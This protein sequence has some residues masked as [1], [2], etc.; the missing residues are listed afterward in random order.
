MG[1]H[2]GQGRF[3]RIQP[4]QQFRIRVVSILIFHRQ[5]TILP[6][7][8]DCFVQGLNKIARVKSRQN[9]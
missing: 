4:L 1:N 5:W 6:K 2:R 7:N 8:F 3:R 9:P